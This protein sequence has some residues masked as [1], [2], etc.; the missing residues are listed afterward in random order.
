MLT[1][2]LFRQFFERSM[3]VQAV[4]DCDGRLSVISDGWCARLGW[5]RDEMAGRPIGDFI[6]PDDRDDLAQRIAAISAAGSACPEMSLARFGVRL[7]ARDGATRPFDLSAAQASDGGIVRLEFCRPELVAD[8]GLHL[9]RTQEIAGVGSWEI[10]LRTRRVYWSEMTH[11]IH[12]T[13][14]DDFVPTLEDAIRFF[15]PEAQEVLRPAVEALLANGT[16]YTLTLPFDTATGER[17]W[18]ETTANAEIDG[19]VVRRAYGTLRDV[20][21][22]RDH[23][24]MVQQLGDVARRTNNLVVITDAERRIVWVNRAFELRT[25][26]SLDEVRGRSPGKLLQCDETDPAEVRRIGDALDALEGVRAQ[27]L[28]RARDG[29]HYW[30]DLDIRPTFA[31]DGGLKGFVGVQIDTTEQKAREAKFQ[32]LADAAQQARSQ[33]VNALEALPDG[34]V[35]FDADGRLV[36]ANSQYRALYPEFAEVLAPGVT[37]EEMLRHALARGAYPEAVGQEEA[38]LAARLKDY[39]SPDRVREIPH[40]VGRWL[41]VLELN[42]S[43]GGRIG[44]RLDVTERRRQYAALEKSNAVLQQILSA[45]DE[46]E[47]RLADIIHGAEV[48]TWEWDLRIGKNV[49]NARW[50]EIVGYDLDEL[51]PFGIDIWRGLLHPDDVSRIEARLGA[52]FRNEMSNFDY[53]M[54]MRHK[55][56]H[57]VWV[58]SRGR[59]VQWSDSGAPVLM[60]GVHIDIT[61]RKRTEQRLDDVIGAA[62]IGTW[63]M[64]FVTGINAINERWATILGYTRDELGEL[65]ISAFTALVHPGD[66]QHLQDLHRSVVPASGQRFESEF[67]MRHRDGRWIWIFSTGRVTR[68]DAAGRALSMSGIHFDITAR[69]AQEEAL[70]AAN[71]RLQAALTE[72]DAAERRFFDIA[73][74]SRDW[75][76]ET[77]ED[78]RYTYISESYRTIAGEMADYRIG[79]T[80]EDLLRLRPEMMQDADWSYLAEEVAQRA[81][82]NDFVYRAVAPDGADLWVRISGAPF[83][84]ADGSFAGYRGVG[85]DVTALYSA[86][87]RAEESSRSKSLFLANM[88][89]EIRTPLNGVLG[90]AELL[91]EAV[92]DP[93][94][95]TMIHTIRE[96][97]EALLNVL[98]DILDMSKIEAG[99]LNLEEIPLIPAD[100]AAK[101][102]RLY[103]LRAQEKG[104]TLSVRAGDGADL[105]RVGDPHRILQVLHNLLSNAIKF[106]ERGR[107]SARIVAPRGGPVKIEVGDTGIGM[108]A[109]QV[110][111]VFDD[112]QQADGTVTRRFGGT[113]LGM[114]IVRRLVEMMG[115]EILVDSAPRKGTTI[116]VTL[117]LPP[118]PANA[119][120]PAA[121]RGAPGNEA[122]TG[123][124]SDEGTPAGDAA[125]AAPPPA[126]PDLGG[127]RVL[128]ADDNATN[129]LILNAML[130]RMGIEAVVAEDGLRAV[131]AYVPGQ[132]DLLLLDISMPEMDGLSALDALRAA[133]DAAGV[134]PAPAIAITANA[135]SHQIAQYLEEGFNAHV[136]KP[137][138]RE[139]LEAAIR[140]V[141]AKA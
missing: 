84:R 55:A 135:M 38:W 18:A 127:L 33:L 31:E 105:A 110:A 43:D 119:P 25:G 41:R 93:R 98:N 120:R 47:R 36:V 72:R 30:V 52:V 14:P 117:P 118:A 29:T 141:L 28:N 70:L 32:Q 49:V 132:F 63:E 82:F 73:K 68:L 109:E 113:G 24:L 112:F 133:D 35:I 131:A 57:W 75:F 6:H 81:P 17:R 54:R 19:G 22:A 101:V 23:A 136:G 26:Y 7:I 34:V 129:R 100:L 46:A 58:Q 86:K 90:M 78:G 16:P 122:P 91:D 50:A 59:V 53:E 124:A 97:G 123:A 74:I 42:T 94:H 87:E 102:G 96:S 39:S 3:T 95:K 99:K 79:K 66:R 44:L 61:D 45:R 69:K 106:T 9:A 48:G 11:R 64:D 126:T 108:T 62:A 76:W 20:T 104:L 115:G 37:I 103:A 88:S 138:R 10:D 130:S 21:E 56:G 107:V 4:I 8:G 139:E 60:A 114:S 116:T 80:R 65:D 51:S 111:R 27:L 77:D 140:T 13:K 128:A 5:R 2:S 71:A 92:E 67:R 134:P 85:S 15:L 1:N 89:H 125:P 83:Y 121:W 12:A 40:T 137:F